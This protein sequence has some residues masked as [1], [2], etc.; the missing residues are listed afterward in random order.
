MR[1]RAPNA[2]ASDAPIQVSHGSPAPH[3]LSGRQDS[4][5]DFDQGI[6]KKVADRLQNIA[7]GLLDR[8]ANQLQKQAD[9]ILKRFGEELQASGKALVHEAEQ[10]LAGVTQASR[11]IWAKS[12]RSCS[13]AFEDAQRTSGSLLEGVKSELRTTLTGLHEQGSKQIAE[14]LETL[15]AGLKESI[16]AQLQKQGEHVAATVGEDLHTLGT[17]LVQDI[18]AH[19]DAATRASLDALHQEAQVAAQEYRTQIAQTLAALPPSECRD[20]GEPAN[21]VRQATETGLAKLDEIQEKIRVSLTALAEDHQRQLAQIAASAVQEIQQSSEALTERVRNELQTAVQSFE[22]T[23][24]QGLTEQLRRSA[25]DLG[26]RTARELQ[27]QA[28]HVLT[29]WGEQIRTSEA[30]R[31]QETQTKLAALTQLSLDSLTQESK[32]LGEESRRQ[33][34][35]VLEQEAENL[36]KNAEQILSSVRRSSEDAAAKLEAAEKNMETSLATFAEDRGQ[37]LSEL[38]AFGDRAASARRGR[39]SRTLPS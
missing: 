23:G 26:E 17:R 33:L 8:C 24:A 4:P 35:K 30:E 32:A 3:N 7:E 2:A 5:R 15:S 31:L 22:Q 14:K 20:S 6:G 29:E 38:A 11:Q 37:R 25:G 9:D 13:T 12:L 18:Q 16:S 36:Q 21:S 39:F 34:A 10:Q 19:V 27:E 1:A 28:D